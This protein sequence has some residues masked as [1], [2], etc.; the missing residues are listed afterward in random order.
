MATGH[1]SRHQE[2]MMATVELGISKDKG[3]RE[4]RGWGYEGL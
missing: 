4:E 2:G 1:C 3:S